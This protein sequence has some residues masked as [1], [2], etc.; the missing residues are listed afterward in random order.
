MKI[1]IFLKDYGYKEEIGDQFCVKFHFV[2]F[3]HNNNN[4]PILYQSGA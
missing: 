2:A 4:N 3:I 1:Y